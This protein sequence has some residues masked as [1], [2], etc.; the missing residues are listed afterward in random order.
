[1]RSQVKIRRVI[2]SGSMVIASGSISGSA[3]IGDIAGLAFW[4][5]DN[6]TTGSMG[7]MGASVLGGTFRLIQDDAN[8]SPVKIATVAACECRIAPADLFP[9]PYIQVTNA[10]QSGSTVIYYS[11]KG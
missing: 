5:D 9:V 7:F 1:M 4:T 8:A 3:Y 2:E 10:A 6:Y 11:G